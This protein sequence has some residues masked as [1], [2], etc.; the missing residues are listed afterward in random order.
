MHYLVWIKR[1][2]WLESLHTCSLNRN[3][4][5]GIY[6]CAKEVGYLFWR[7]SRGLAALSGLTYVF[8][9]T[10][11]LR[12]FLCLSVTS[13]LLRRKFMRHKKCTDVPCHLSTLLFQWVTCCSW[14]LN[15]LFQNP[16]YCSYGVGTTFLVDT[17]TELEILL[18]CVW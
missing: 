5:L 8:I 6:I 13:L 3:A 4:M 7:T 18:A 2:I 15:L 14:M 11:H 10:T 16:K 9:L 1:L 17:K 12:F